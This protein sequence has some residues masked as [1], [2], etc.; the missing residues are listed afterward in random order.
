MPEVQPLDENQFTDVGRHEPHDPFGHSGLNATPAP[1]VRP[2]TKATKKNAVWIV[3]GL[4]LHLTAVALLVGYLTNWFAFMR[5]PE[6]DRPEEKK[7][8]ITKPK[9]KPSG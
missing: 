7:T 2:R 6:P 3:L 8:T 1:I 4:I 5:P 9:A